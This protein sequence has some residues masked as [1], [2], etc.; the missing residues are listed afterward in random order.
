[1]DAVSLIVA[2]AAGLA[3]LLALAVAGRASRRG[4]ELGDRVAGE[5]EPYLRRKAAEIGI[6][7]P[8]PVWTSR[9][10]PEEKVAFA[11]RLA[12]SLLDHERG[13]SPAS[14]STALAQTVP[15]ADSRAVTAPRDPA[16]VGRS[17]PEE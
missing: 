17:T 6:D 15:V 12:R 8:S 1:M 13:G 11:S 16:P 4:R 9:H 14:S 10:S 3:A 5:V 7:S 2:G